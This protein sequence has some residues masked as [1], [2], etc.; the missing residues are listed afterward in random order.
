[1]FVTFT[2]HVEYPVLQ[3]NSNLLVQLKNHY[4]R[5]LSSAAALHVH[6]GVQLTDIFLNRYHY[7]NL[8]TPD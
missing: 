2:F 8:D 4:T 7:G 1:M 3:K 6:T 5:R